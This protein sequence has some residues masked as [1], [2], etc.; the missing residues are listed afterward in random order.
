M[1]W[2]TRQEAV[3]R[4]VGKSAT[5]G[6]YAAGR[7][8]A[9]AAVVQVWSAVTLSGAERF[10][11]VLVIWLTKREAVV[12]ILGSAARTAY[13]VGRFETPAAAMQAP[14]PVTV[15]G[16]EQLTVVFEF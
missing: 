5:H 11:T 1:I 15:V 7:L 13:A 3:V 14:R 4:T 6:A 9:P 10:T 2:L 12:R 16:A 8:A